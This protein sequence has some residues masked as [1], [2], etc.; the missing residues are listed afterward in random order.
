[1]VAVN[2]GDPC[3]FN[4]PHEIDA[5]VLEEA[6]VFD[7]G[8][9]L[10]HDLGNVIVLHQLP[11]GAL[12]G[13]EK[14]GQHLGLELVGLQFSGRAAVDGGNRAAGDRD[15]C[16]LLTVIRLGAGHFFD[17]AAVQTIAAQRRFAFFFRI[18]GMTQFSRNVRDGRLRSDP[19]HLRGSENLG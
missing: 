4:Q 9:R 12:L 19:D 14:R 16:R 15:G 3:G 6:A 10:H 2:E 17:G 11:L 7:G 18:A 1:M 8:D 13:I 5:I